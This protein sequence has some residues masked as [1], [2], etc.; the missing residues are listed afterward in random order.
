MAGDHRHDFNEFAS[1]WYAEQREAGKRAAKVG[2]LERSA[3]V[4]EIDMAQQMIDYYD[5]LLAEHRDAVVNGEPSPHA[6]AD[7]DRAHIEAENLRRNLAALQAVAA[8]LPETP[9]QDKGA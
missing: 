1:T 4:E 9:T 7:V 3:V 6:P 8:E 2:A 5:T